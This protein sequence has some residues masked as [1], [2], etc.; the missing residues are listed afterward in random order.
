MEDIKKEIKNKIYKILNPFNENKKSLI[1]SLVE[2]TKENCLMPEEKIANSIIFAENF[3]RSNSNSN[4]N[5][6]SFKNNTSSGSSIYMEIDSRDSEH[7]TKDTTV[8]NKVLEARNNI[9]QILKENTQNEGDLRI[10]IL[11]EITEELLNN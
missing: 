5:S 8:T 6:H 11:N 7:D 10:E 2:L 4:S 3:S 9:Y 1:V